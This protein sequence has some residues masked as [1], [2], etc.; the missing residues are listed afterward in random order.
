MFG[1]GPNPIAAAIKKQRQDS[2]EVRRTL[3]H[4]SLKV[5]YSGTYAILTPEFSDIL[6]NLTTIYAPKVFPF[7]KI[8]PEYS[9]I[10]Y[11]LTYIPGPMV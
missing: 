10:L 2:D 3:Y 6:R 8:K 7:T 5:K 9:D 11:N 1:S 4:S